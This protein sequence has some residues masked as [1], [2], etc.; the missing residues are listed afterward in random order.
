MKATEVQQLI[1][2]RGIIK[3]TKQAGQHG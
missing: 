1:I 2:A 3:A